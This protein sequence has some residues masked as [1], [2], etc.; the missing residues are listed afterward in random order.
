MKHEQMW[1]LNFDNVLQEKFEQRKFVKIVEL[2]HLILTG[3]QTNV[4][5]AWKTHG[6]R[7]ILKWL[8]IKGFGDNHWIQP[9]FMN[10]EKAQAVLEVFIQ[11]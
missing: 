5:N 11:I 1:L 4:Q 8:L 7:E 3:I 2:G 9:K 6:V 10:A